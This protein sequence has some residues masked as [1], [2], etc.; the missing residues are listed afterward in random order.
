MAEV[1]REV[2]RKYVADLDAELPPLTDLVAGAAG[3]PEVS[4]GAEPVLLEATYFDTDDLRLAAAGLTL[5]RRTGGADAGWHLK[6]PAGADAREEV[7]L[8]TG[9]SVRT[10]PAPLRAMVR[11]VAGD[12]PLRPVAEVRTDRT[13]HRLAD[14]T[15]RVLLE[16]V[17][18]RVAARRVRSTQGLGDAT[19]AESTW[20]EVEVELV[21]G[22]GDLL[23]VLEE[24]LDAAGLQASPARS[25]LQRV[26]GDVDPPR[27]GRAPV[28]RTSPAGAVIAAYL[29]EQLDRLRSQDL[30]VRLD[31]PG[32]VH[33]MRV[34]A[35][36]SRGA[37]GT[38]RPLFDAAAVGPLRAELAWLADVLGAARDAEVLRARVRSGVGAAADD[39]AAG[40]ADAALGRAAQEARQAL[41]SA[42]DDDRYH[43][44]LRG[45]GAF[46]ADP[47]LTERG[48]STARAGLRGPVARRDRKV[49][50][51]LE[52]AR[53]A[54]RG[55]TRDEA[56]HR[57]R[58]AAK[59]ARYA[60]EAVRPAFGKDARRYA[61]AMEALQEVLGEHHDAVVA[62]ARLR[63]L[64][65][66][67][68]DT[69]V[70]F[71]YGRL[72]AAEEAR[73]REAERGVRPA[74]RAARGRKLRR[75]FG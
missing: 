51:R 10:V 15:G 37:L 70:A 31:A 6:V 59:A 12:A 45:L 28:G 74:A 36:R 34:A 62:R 24:R 56:L 54:A 48:R 73:G 71:L 25:K 65:R 32:A 58:K 40:V 19:G 47:P 21:E 69:G 14:A 2:E 1:H 43:A 26:L 4:A 42:L 63:E 55:R 16:V 49:G 52:R 72:H 18:D 66:V 23:D 3:L 7:R 27:A 30:P 57:A 53:G 75:W 22:A 46:V 61:R 50:R 33:R 20:R 41:L 44:L 11:A 67:A 9:R 60:G 64:A 17:D 8:P 13:V 68:P 5:R 38:F 35:R 39:P 29:A